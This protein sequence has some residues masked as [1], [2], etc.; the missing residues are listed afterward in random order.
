MLL[1]EI[2]AYIMFT[3]FIMIVASRVLWLVFFLFCFRIWEALVSFELLSTYMEITNVR[4]YFILIL[5]LSAATYFLVMI[6]TKDI[7]FLRYVFL[8]VMVIY[9]LRVHEITDILFF[10]DYL[11]AAGLWDLEF[12]KNQWKQLLSFSITD[13]Q[14]ILGNIWG[15]IIS[16]FERIFV[17]AKNI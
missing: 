16:F 2:A 3:V 8:L 17:G 13:F 12:W 7:A 9:T 6:V 4:D 10:K 5:I 15:K 14:N 1:L 11:E